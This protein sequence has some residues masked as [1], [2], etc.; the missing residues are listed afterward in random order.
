MEELEAY[1]EQDQSRELIDEEAKRV[2]FRL[3]GPLGQGHNIVVHIHG[4]ASRIDEFRKLIGRMI[5]L[6]NHMR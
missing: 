5:P 1:N 2:K 4:L 6:D 3:L